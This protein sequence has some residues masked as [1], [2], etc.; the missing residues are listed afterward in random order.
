MK[1]KILI[2]GG[3]GLLGSYLTELLQQAG[4]QVVHL[5]RRPSG[6]EKVP[7]FRWDP[8][9]AWLDPHALEGVGGIIHLAG[10]PVAAHRWTQKYKTQLYESRIQSA[11]LLYQALAARKERPEVFI[12]AS[13]VG[14]Y[15]SENGAHLLQE[16]SPP[17]TDFL[18]G[19]CQAWEAEAEHLEELGLR[20]LKIRLGVVLSA[21]GGAL[22][23]MV[24]PTRLGLGAPLGSGKQYLSW[25][26]IEDAC[27]IILKLLQDPGTKGAY[28]LVAPQP[29]TNETFMR[30]LAEV[31]DKPFWAPRVPAAALK[32]AMG[33]QAAI[34]LGSQRVSCAR[35]E[36]AGYAFRYPSLRKAL[37]SLLN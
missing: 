11:R 4:L 32:L 36:A 8:E 21:Q 15:G 9:T 25:I 2:T 31:L 26:H 27:R 7:T 34:V 19:L 16:S 30:V 20:V 33:E 23:K 10:A 14:Y 17:G 28:N 35:I 13:G 1:N 18:A 22:E 3:S 29:E 12:T 5:S 6:K 37:Q 24:Q